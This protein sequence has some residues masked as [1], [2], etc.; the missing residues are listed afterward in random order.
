MS[1]EFSTCISRAKKCGRFGLLLIA[2]LACCTLAVSARQAAPDFSGV[3]METNPQ[4]GPPMRLKLNQNG[5]QL[6]VRMS[7][8]GTFGDQ[9]FGVATIYNNNTAT[10]S[11]PQG[12]APRFRTAGYDYSNPGVNTFTLVLRRSMNSGIPTWV[13]RYSQDVVWNAPCGGHPVG[14]ERI[15]KMLT[16]AGE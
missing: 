10:W 12:C 4:S 2:G 1:I 16:K 3:W 15:R 13:I 7:Y 8:T 9:P 5:S 11:A 6:E 14:T